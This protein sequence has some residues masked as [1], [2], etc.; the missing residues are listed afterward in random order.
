FFNHAQAPAIS[1][2]C[3]TGRDGLPVGLQIAGPRG[4]DWRVLAAARLVE[5]LLA[6]G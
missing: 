1:V 6:A 3:G 5:Q 2:P 4:A